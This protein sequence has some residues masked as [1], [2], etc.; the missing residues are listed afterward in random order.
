MAAEDEF[1]CNGPPRA[2]EVLVVPNEPL[3]TMR[4]PGDPSRRQ[5]IAWALYDWGNSAFAL[6]VLTVFFPV[7]L[8]RYWIGDAGVSSTFVLGMAN[9]LASLVIVVLAP[10]LGAIADAAAAR[11]RWLAAFAFMGAL[12]CVLLGL[13]EAGQWPMATLLFML[14][15][16]G[17]SGA[18][19]FYDALLVGVAGPADRER[20]SAFGYALG[21]LGGS[22]LFILNA[23][24]VTKPG[25]FGLPDAA[26]ATRLAF[27]SVGIWWAVFT[28][29]LLKRVPE[30][31]A[32]GA[33]RARGAVRAGLRQLAATLRHVRRYRAVVIFLVAYWFYIDGVDTIVRMAVDFGQQLGF[34]T[35][36]LILAIL[37]TNLIGFPATIG[38]GL[39]A[40]RIGARRGIL[41]GLGVYIAITIGAYFI[42]EAWHFYL[43]AAVVGLVQGGVQATSRAFYS[44]LIPTDRAA[45][46]FGFYNMLGKFAAV[47]G[48]MMVGWTAAW[49]GDPRVAILTVLVLFVVGGGLLL[50][51]PRDAGGNT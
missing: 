7:F 16:I 29:P 19:V 17:F 6:S 31:E 11:K 26:T 1:W 47:L 3:S 36:D 45:E 22:V 51:V 49:S 42:S 33:G 28:V 20:V 39:L 37:L 25:W 14:G 13:V 4:A 43:L 40:R 27:V 21:Y 18:N 32:V 30:P 12:M 46:F 35:Q 9:G 5:V 44:R 50:R 34:D 23:L 15:V 10:I 2:I 24:M 48:P 38:F 8:G 41:V